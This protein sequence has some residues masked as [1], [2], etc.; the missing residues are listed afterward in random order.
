LL[1]LSKRPTTHTLAH[2][3]ISAQLCGM[4][5][6]TR[7]DNQEKWYLRIEDF[8]SREITQIDFCQESGLNKGTFVYWLRKYR[9]AV[10]EDGPNGFIALHPSGEPALNFGRQEIMLRV[11]AVELSLPSDQRLETLI[12]L[13]KGLA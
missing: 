11:G 3:N 6:T 7:Q 10:K 5:K 13:I 4:K 9:A 12:P 8:L 1:Y 2:P